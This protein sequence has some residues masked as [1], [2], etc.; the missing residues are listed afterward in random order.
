MFLH[1]DDTEKKLY[2]HAEGLKF[3]YF[4]IHYLL[5]IICMGVCSV[6]VFVL[7]KYFSFN[8]VIKINFRLIIFNYQLV[9]CFCYLCGSRYI[10]YSVDDHPINTYIYYVVLAVMHTT[11]ASLPRML[12]WIM[13]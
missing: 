10:Q 8:I 1:K 3:T 6:C 7:W 12:T 2:V 5:S 11:L 9:Y 4:G 13:F